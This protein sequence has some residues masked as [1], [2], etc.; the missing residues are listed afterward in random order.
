M[1]FYICLYFSNMKHY[2]I[3]SNFM[4]SNIKKTAEQNIKNSSAIKTLLSIEKI[5]GVFR[6]LKYSKLN[7][8]LRLYSIILIISLSCVPF[9]VFKYN[10]ALYQYARRMNIVVTSINSAIYITFCTLKSKSFADLLSS[11]NK[12]HVKISRLCQRYTARL[13]CL[14]RIIVGCFCS[15]AA[16]VS[17]FVIKQLVDDI[18]RAQGFSYQILIIQLIIIANLLRGTSQHLMYYSILSIM[19][20]Q[21]E[22]LKDFGMK[23]EILLLLTYENRKSTITVDEQDVEVTTLKSWYRD[24][25]NIVT[26]STKTNDAFGTA[27]GI[28]SL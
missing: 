17:C 19:S 22:Y 21:L 2:N 14:H 10:I 23:N 20:Y 13:K 7:P 6:N 11:L 18:M 25:L 9:I 3:N 27:V 24:Y 4:S 5:F 28:V 12:T 16:I 15:L 1:Y 8:M 26:C